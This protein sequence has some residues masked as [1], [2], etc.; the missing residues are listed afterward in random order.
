[1][2]QINATTNELIELSEQRFTDLGFKEREHLQEWCD[3][4][5]N[6]NVHECM[7]IGKIVNK[8]DMFT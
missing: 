7:N 3:V 4:H 2:Y 1:M 8:L 6:C 5:E